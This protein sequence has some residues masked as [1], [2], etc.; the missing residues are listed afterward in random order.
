MD[1]FYSF[2]GGFSEG[3]GFWFVIFLLQGIKNIKSA[4]HYE[5]QYPGE[6]SLASACLTEESTERPPSFQS[7][8]SALTTVYPIKIYLILL[9]I[10]GELS[11]I[12]P[13]VVC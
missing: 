12:D 1:L 7:S 5:T 2:K 3:W 8:V 9:N 6:E 13:L 11:F 10:S 4:A